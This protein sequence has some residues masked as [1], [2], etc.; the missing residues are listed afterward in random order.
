VAPQQQQSA[1]YWDDSKDVFSNMLSS[2]THRV[3]DVWHDSSSSFLG[4]LWDTANVPIVSTDEMSRFANFLGQ[5]GE[6][7]GWER[8]LFSLASGFTSPLQLGLTL[9]TFGTSALESGGASLLSKAGMGADEIASFTKAIPT[10]MEGTALQ[11]T[12]AEIAKDVA[13]KGLD[14]SVFEKGA[15]ILKDAQLDPSYMVRN[16]VIHRVASSML[17]GA[18]GMGETDAGIVSAEKWAKAVQVGVDLGFTAPMALSLPVISARAHDALKEGDYDKFG[19]LAVEALGGTAFSVLGASAMAHEAG[20]LWQDFKGASGL[21]QRPS[22]SYILTAREFGKT[23]KENLMAQADADSLLRTAAEEYKDVSSRDKLMAFAHGQLAFDK[24][25]LGYAHNQ[26]V[27]SAGRNDLVIPE[28]EPGN[29]TPT[30][31]DQAMDVLKK[32]GMTD[33]QV[34]M[35]SDENTAIPTENQVRN[36]GEALVQFSIPGVGRDGIDTTITRPAKEVDTPGKITA[37]INEKRKEFGMPPLPATKLHEAHADTEG[38][39]V[40]AVLAASTP[41]NKE[42]PVDAV[43]F[44]DNFLKQYKENGKIAPPETENGNG[45]SIARRFALENLQRV[46]DHV[47]GD[48]KKA[49]EWLTTEHPVDEVRQVKGRKG[50]AG[51]PGKDG[52]TVVGAKALG[53]G[54]GE[55]FLEIHN[56]N[57]KEY[58]EAA[59]EHFAP[60]YAYRLR[61]A[62]EQG[63]PV[64]NEHAQ[65]SISKD[66]ILPYAAH[67]STE[68]QELVRVDLNKLSPE[69]YEVKPGPNGHGWVRFKKEVPEDA[70][71][72]DQDVSPEQAQQY[73]QDAL[74]QKSPKPGSPGYEALK[75]QVEEAQSD[76]KPELHELQSPEIG[77]VKSLPSEKV[78]SYLG[79][80][81]K[82][83]ADGEARAASLA[84]QFKKNPSL[85][86]ELGPID[87]AFDKY[88]DLIG[89][90]RDAAIKA[91]AAALAGD[92]TLPVR[93]QQFSY[94]MMFQPS[95]KRIYVDAVKA[96]RSLMRERVEDLVKEAHLAE[97]AKKDP[98][99]VDDL[100]YAHDPRNLTP[101][102][103]EFARKAFDYDSRTGEAAERVGML[104]HALSNHMTN[105]WERGD[106]D[107]NYASANLLRNEMASSRFATNTTLARHKK[108]EI[109][110]DGLLLGKK[111]KYADPM[112]LAAYNRLEFARALNHK[113]FIERVRAMGLEGSDGMPAFAPSGNAR[114]IEG[115]N[116]EKLGW[117][118]DPKHVPDMRISQKM[119]G[120]LQK[121]GTLDKLIAENKIKVT[122]AALTEEN[123][124][125]A[126]DVIWNKEI[127][128]MG[129]RDSL[130]PVKQQLYDYLMEKYNAMRDVKDSTTPEARQAALDAYNEKYKS[131]YRWVPNGYK[132]IDHSAMKDWRWLG[133]NSNG[134]PIYL[135]GDILVHPEFEPYLR[136][137]LGREENWGKNK[138]VRAAMKATTEAKGMV[139]G[140]DMF[141]MWQEGLRGLMTRISPFGAHK[142][143]FRTSLVARMVAEEG[144]TFGRET[145][146]ADDFMASLEG[147]AHSKLLSAVPGIGPALGKFQSFLFDQYIPGLKVRAAEKLFDRYTEKYPEM[148]PREIA[149]LVGNDINNRF[150]G[151]NYARMGRALNTQNVMRLFA[152]APDWL[153]SETR[154]YSSLFGGHSALNRTD[155]IATVLALWGTARVLNYMNT[156]NAHYEAPFALA[157]TDK[158]GREKL[159]SVRTLPT[160]LMHLIEDPSG[161]MRGRR[162]PLFR[163]AEEAYTGT[164][165]FGRKLPEHNRIIS[166]AESIAHNAMPMQ[167]QTAIKQA[168][169]EMPSGMTTGDSIVKM[170]G[171]T[172][173]QHKTEA[174]KR[175]AELASM[176]SSNGPV[177]ESHLKK[178]QAMINVEDQIRAGEVPMTEINRMFDEGLI[179]ANDARDMQRRIQ[180]TRDMDPDTARLYSRAARLPLKQFLEVY[181]LGTTQEKGALIQLLKSKKNAYLKR[182]AKDM[183]ADERANDPTYRTIR[184]RFPND[185]AV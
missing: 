44:A 4:K 151:Q 53:P 101:R 181:D 33:V 138:V 26:I 52:G 83:D 8:G 141:H 164:D 65:A 3:S 46:L 32:S 176:M 10:Y 74:S 28:Y 54:I 123:L 126:L 147:H 17:R 115:D 100:I 1:D 89:F 61:N 137:I 118:V 121:R 16:S 173:Q 41:G 96:E 40:S 132:F 11:K 50:N 92:T 48:E 182:A 144:G 136:K 135:H 81:G 175:S 22:D 107:T 124:S 15:A 80:N 64:K 133:A 167:M 120:V 43:R 49:V 98:Q 21:S 152:L 24:D 165:E 154:Y 62:G 73:L 97:L 162:S 35:N 157:T 75:K 169:G 29:S 99:W 67:R 78:L 150:G 163:T 6:I 102:I 71:V 86:Q 82:L 179:S 36:N 112:G 63:I 158:E 30:H 183:T 180:Q 95:G 77:Q 149:R 105:L 117:L 160:D 12:T 7:P 5:D 109:Y 114:E 170:F 130:P 127:N 111:L 119:L 68:P 185:L 159:F 59:A 91:K 161:F 14:A 34:S 23:Q 9:G 18:G 174:A 55:R 87:I 42:N 38:G 56:G 79:E 60:K 113:N 142:V 27:K 20:S 166:L 156:G 153:E 184:A 58:A 128:P 31:A 2:F 47:G 172:V 45:K 84:E 148:K 94:S 104:N 90:D 57:G 70:V 93:T 139:L 103:E 72:K 134:V 110:L 143:D 25:L 168:T 146:G 69:D 122:N 51:I 171:A 108:Y 66:E 88:S 19:E 106:E 131:T 116:G 129:N 13:A 85:K 125:T 140:L 155:F 37:V 177:D 178:H 145:K 76:G 39:L